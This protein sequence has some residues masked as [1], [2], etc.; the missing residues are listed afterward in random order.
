MSLRL[1]FFLVVWTLLVV[2]L[3][4]LGALLGRWSTVEI[5][6]VTAEAQIDRMLGDAGQELIEA[7]LLAPARDSSTL[8]AVLAERVAAD[9]FVQG[10]AVLDATGR[11]VASALPPMKPGEFTTRPDGRF[12]WRREEASDGRRAAIRLIGD[13]R[14]IDPRDSLDPRYLVVLPT[15]H[16]KVSTAAAPEP[17]ASVALA[18]RVR[19]AL[20]IGSILAALVTVAISGP[21]L[22]RVG[23]L[24]RAVARLGRGDLAARVDVRGGDEIARLGGAFNAMAGDLERA[25]SQRRQMVTDVAHELRTPLTNITG[26]L[27]AVEDGLR[28]PDAETIAALQEEAGLLAGLID[29]LRDLSLAESGHL[30]LT[31]EPVDAAQAVHR[32]VDGF[33]RRHAIVVDVPEHPVLVQADARR[34]GQVLRNLIQNAVTHSPAA[35][36]VTVTLSSRAEAAERPRSRDP[37]PRRSGPVSASLVVSRESRAGVQITVCDRGPGIPPDEL[38]RIWDRFYRTDASRTRAT[39]GMGLGLPVARQLVE[40]MGGTIT[41]T[42]EVGQ[43]SMFAVTLDRDG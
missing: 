41:V 14:V 35:G 10:A 39:G 26:L 6:R 34:F 2:G 18:A 30:Q 8:S 19:W 9:S 15:L 17:E 3:V 1:R 33:D 43:G 23:E 42:S 20:L 40:A 22:G 16:A 13:G 27:E 31:V 36:S 5:S 11:V 4:G 32:A 38:P 24:S 28:A 37:V 12:E 7:V 21:L 29:D 25:E